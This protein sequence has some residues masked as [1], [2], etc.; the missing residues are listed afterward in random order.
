MTDERLQT[1]F[2]A[3][4]ERVGQFLESAA[5][6]SVLAAM[7]LLATTQIVLRNFMDSGFAWGDEALRL[8][9]LWVAML[10]A[11]AASRENRHIAI[12]ALSRILP[13]TPKAWA[14]VVVHA[15]TSAIAFTLAWYAWEFVAESRE[16]EDLLLGDLPAWWFQSI[17][18][19]GFLLIGYRY[20]I[21]FARELV[22]AAPKL[23]RRGGA[24]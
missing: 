19:V 24:Q 13:Q 15:F 11:V 6:V 7:V 8:M 21:W 9:V 2:L 17:I 3:R 14:A 5:L 4:A 1:G 18:P 23:F 16:Y 12:D 20:A 10:G 22:D